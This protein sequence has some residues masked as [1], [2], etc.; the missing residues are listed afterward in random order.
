[1][2][3]IDKLNWAC[4]IIMVALTVF[5]TGKV[6]A[7]TFTWMPVFLMS[8][9]GIP[10]WFDSCIRRYRQKLDYIERLIEQHER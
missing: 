1:M 8:V 5:V 3:T 2:K 9:Y 4:A 7:I 6:D 10:L